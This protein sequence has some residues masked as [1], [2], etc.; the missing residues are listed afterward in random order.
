M[1]MVGTIPA[2]DTTRHTPELAPHP[3]PEH[4]KGRTH[5]MTSLTRRRVAPAVAVRVVVSLVAIVAVG[6]ACVAYVTGRIPLSPGM[7]F[8]AAALVAAG[9]LTRRFGIPLPGGG[10]S[11]YILGVVLYAT[12]DQGWTFAVLIAPLAVVAGDR[13]LRQIPLRMALNN[14]VHVAAGS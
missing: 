5:P 7:P 2:L 3:A 10:F 9:V 11:S 12:L 1:R 6:A 8:A 4:A 14:A 13:L